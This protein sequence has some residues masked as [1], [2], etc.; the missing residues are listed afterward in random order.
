MVRSARSQVCADL[1]QL[2]R[3]VDRRNG[4]N[5]YTGE[6]QIVQRDLAREHRCVAILAVFRCGRTWGASEYPLDL[7]TGPSRTACVAPRL[8]RVPRREHVLAIERLKSSRF[9]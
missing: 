9:F 8:D 3:S 7:D 4:T 1:V 6:T 2:R 5:L